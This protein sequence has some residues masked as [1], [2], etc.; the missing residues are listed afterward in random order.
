[1]L[2]ENLARA[3]SADLMRFENI[4]DTADRV[5]QLGLE[6]VIHLCAQSANHHVDDVSVSR[7][8]HLP[9]LLCD[10]CARHDRAG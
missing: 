3:T 9:D 10:F 5:N 6:R 4:T 2:L 8:P 1:M 7:K